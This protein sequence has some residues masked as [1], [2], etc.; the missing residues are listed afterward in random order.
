MI[1]INQFLK[2]VFHFINLSLITLYLYPGS[3]FGYI[4]YGNFEKQPKISADFFIISSNHFYAFMIL[5]ISG[6]L[7]YLNKNK[8]NL[9]I[10]YLIALSIV[11]ELL[12][13]IIPNRTFQFSDLIGN[14][15]GVL[16][17]CFFFIILNK[18]RF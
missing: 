6:F 13:I 18:I 5:S 9:L 10:I 7:A 14:I 1:R 2:I 15:M 11:L 3:V 16:I 12:Q 17:V 8:I 4:L